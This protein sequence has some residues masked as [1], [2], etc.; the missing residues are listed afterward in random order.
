MDSPPA[1]AAH[2]EAASPWT[3]P[4]QLWF[5]SLEVTGIYGVAVLLFVLSIGVWAFFGVVAFFLRSSVSYPDAA[6]VLLGAMF[7]QPAAEI[8]GMVVMIV[9]SIFITRAAFRQAGWAHWGAIALVAVSTLPVIQIAVFLSQGGT[10]SRA[11]FQPVIWL[12]AVAYCVACAAFVMAM[13]YAFVMHGPWG[14]AA[15]ETSP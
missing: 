2:R 9:A 4:L 1:Q 15:Q 5:V 8:A 12:A 6:G 13:T 11:P 7:G 14:V 10:D 3:R